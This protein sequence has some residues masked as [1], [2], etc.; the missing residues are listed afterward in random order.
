M[1]FDPQKR[2]A[3]LPIIFSIILILGIWIG[4]FLS[5]N[6]ASGLNAFHHKKEGNGEKIN[7]LLDYIEYQY[8]DT[9]NK[10]DLA[11]KTVTAMLQSLDPHS[12]YIPASEIE[13]TNESLEGNFDSTL[14][15]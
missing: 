12:S 2:N 9:I 14:G 15:P 1:I 4:Y 5:L 13:M 8:V 10:S 7:S 6:F 3:F 11:E